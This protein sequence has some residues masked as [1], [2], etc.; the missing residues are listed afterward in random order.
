MTWH[1]N[2]KYLLN[3]FIL[4]LCLA[5]SLDFI[6]MHCVSYANFKLL[7]Q[8]VQESNENIFVKASENVHR[9]LSVH[10]QIHYASVPNKIL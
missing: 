3:Y 7:L 1:K 9:K 10:N 2:R 8:K 4:F 5:N 6:F